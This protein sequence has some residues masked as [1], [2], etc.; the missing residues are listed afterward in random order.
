MTEATPR[1]WFMNVNGRDP[2]PEIVDK[3]GEPV[4]QATSAR[5]GKHRIEDAR[6]IV[7]A[8][9]SYDAMREALE[10]AEPILA[11]NFRFLRDTQASPSKINAAAHAWDN[12]RAALKLAEGQP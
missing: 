1:P 6:L 10:A 8:V 4:A 11:E 9:N 12:A 5:L 7:K 3:Y 2:Y